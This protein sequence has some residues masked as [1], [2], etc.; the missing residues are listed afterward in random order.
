M[1]EL[2]KYLLLTGFSGFNNSVFM[3]CLINLFNI[4]YLLAQAVSTA[5]IYIINYLVC[6]FWIFREPAYAE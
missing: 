5:S 3:Y 2:S 6:K 1:A 4:N